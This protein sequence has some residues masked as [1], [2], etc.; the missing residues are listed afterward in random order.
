MYRYKENTREIEK[1]KIRILD[2]LKNGK[3]KKLRTIRE[4]NENKVRAIIS[5]ISL[6]GSYRVARIKDARMRKME[7]C[8]Q[9]KS[10]RMRQNFKFI[11]FRSI[12][13]QVSTLT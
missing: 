1:K 13:K 12:L 6:L 9:T 11:T 8:S 10:R 7:K 4:Q 5:N 3:K 2:K